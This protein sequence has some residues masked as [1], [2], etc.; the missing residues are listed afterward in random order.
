MT[1]ED[2]EES[3]QRSIEDTLE[4]VTEDVMGYN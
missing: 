1:A 4:S 2:T 3:E